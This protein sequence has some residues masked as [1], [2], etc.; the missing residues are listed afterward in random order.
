MSY[1]Q[2]TRSSSDLPGVAEGQV[3]TANAAGLRHLLS[4][5]AYTELAEPGYY[6]YRLHLGPEEHTGL[7]AELDVGGFVDGQVLGHE[8]VQAERVQA[9]VRHFEAV[10][11]RS[12]LVTVVHRHQDDV[13]AVVSATTLTDPVLSFT[14]TTGVEQVVWRVPDEL[15]SVVSSALQDSRFYLADGHHRVAATVQRWRDHG[16]PR[17][18]GVLSVLY[19]ED[20]VHLLAFHRLVRPGPQPWDVDAVLGAFS[21]TSTVEPVPGPDCGP[22]EVGLRMGRAWYRLRLP[23]D[24]EAGAAGLDVAVLD[25]RVLAAS[26]GVRSGDPSVEY[27]S[28]L[29]DLD[30]AVA[31]VDR[32]GA[33]LFLLAAPS[34][35]QLVDVAE[36][37]QVMP[38]KSTYIEPKPRAGV[39]LR[40]RLGPV[41]PANLAP[42]S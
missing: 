20:Q 34:L 6:I 1:L 4:G 35:D 21:R 18:G 24:R 10:P 31:E 39:L 8:A 2:V 7:V 3:G 41:D 5:G 26:L 27:V 32:V 29:S 11:M 40:P 38:Q 23:G 16:S 17:G 12:E 9:L 37:G 30:A 14:D 33:A 15:G 13:A 25:E 22:G 42:S 19:P 36:R 28:E